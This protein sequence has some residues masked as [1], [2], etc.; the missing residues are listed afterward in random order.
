MIIWF[1]YALNII[2]YQHNDICK[3]AVAINGLALEFEI[4]KIALTKT[5]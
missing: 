4:N 5:E 2:N 3:Y 1:P